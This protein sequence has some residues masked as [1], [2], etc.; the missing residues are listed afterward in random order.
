[1]SSGDRNRS[2]LKAWV[3]ALEL[4]API[5]ANPA[6]TLP[7]RVDD[8]ADEFGSAPALIS[9]SVSLSYRTL[10]EQSNRY[11]RWALRQGL[12]AGDVVCLFMLNCPEYVAIWLGISHTGCV[13]SLVNSNL[14]GDALA[15]A[16]NVVAPK[17]VIAG[18]ELLD[19]VAAVRPQLRSSVK[20]WAHGGDGH[21][22]SRVDEFVRGFSGER[23]ASSEGTRPTTADRAL[24]IYTSGTTGLP[25]AANVSHHRLMQ[26]S[27]WFAG[28]LD[29]QPS[30][31]MYNCLPLFH[32]TGGV[33]AVGAM[34]V[35]GGSVV[36]RPHFSASRFWDEVI[37]S[38]CTMFQYIGELCRFLVNSPPNPRERDHQLRVCCGNGLAADV[39]GE[40]EERFQIPRIVEFY[41]ATEA[42]F[43]LFN[44]EGKRGS[45]GK[46]PSFLAHRFPLA[47]VQFDIDA[48]EPTRGVDGFC[49]RCAPNEAGEA[50]SR[51]PSGASRLGGN[52]EGYSDAAES[53]RKVLRNVFEPG[54]A[55]FRTGDLMRQDAEGFY[56]F[57]DR[58]GD[59]F[60]WKGENVSTTEVAAV[61]SAFPGVVEAI[62]YGVA[63]PGSEGRAG[64]AAIVAGTEFDPA[65]CAR[66]LAERLPE[67]ARPLFLRFRS[68]IE[69]TS[70]FKPRRQD[71]VR[72]GY[73]P[74]RTTDALWFSDRAAGTFVR[75]DPTLFEKINTGAIR[76]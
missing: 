75:I 35:R 51:I 8:L 53:D 6:V 9:G 50:I 32:S 60:R 27:Y 52:F 26:W 22:F 31:R 56:Y 11:A 34:L 58:I 16:V 68:A 4:T 67:Y 46:V 28:I 48:G 13:V 70:T 57:V 1:M 30:D 21:G 5:A 12:V 17:H 20:C 7:D 65:A 23:L 43:S 37:D 71:L 10:S 24:Y 73:D 29:I 19:S 74:S 40:F 55:W 15:H 66:H 69:M 2:P 61:V 62:V 47:L 63:V 41:A 54:D 39:W 14:T 38:G 3:R 49:A 44:C 64:M 59:T 36:V 33:V 25:K 18:P 72:D 45:I 42:N 76:L